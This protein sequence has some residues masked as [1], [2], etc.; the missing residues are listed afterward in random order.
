MEVDVFSSKEWH[1]LGLRW[2]T[3]LGFLAALC[4]A[5]LGHRLIDVG[6][7]DLHVAAELASHR[8]LPDDLRPDAVLKGL[9]VHAGFGECG[10]QTIDGE[11][12]FLRHAFEDLRDVG[13]VGGGAGLPGRLSLQPFVDQH[14]GG[15][16][17]QGR[18]G[19]LLRGNGQE[20][21][22][23][24]D[25]VVGDRV[26][27]DEDF[28][29]NLLRQSRQNA[30]EQSGQEQ[31]CPDQPGPATQCGTGSGPH[32]SGILQVACAVRHGPVAY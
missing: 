29:R 7:R 25:I 24:V 8:I 28:D 26:V 19:L 11:I 20:A 13:L 27:I 6:V 17:L 5:V 10:G 3:S 12:V 1:S 9:D 4:S 32:R 30:A 16:F 23:L 21:L 15:L 18:G 2:L 14:V 22:A 31:E